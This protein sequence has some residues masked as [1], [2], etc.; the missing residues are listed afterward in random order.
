[1]SGTNS[2]Q[3]QW[4]TGHVRV[5]AAVFL[6]LSMLIS[7]GLVALAQD[8]LGARAAQYGVFCIKGTVIDHDETPLEGFVVRA[9]APTGA[10]FDVESDEDGYFEFL[11]LDA[12]IYTV[13]VVLERAYTL[14][15]PYLQVLSVNLEYGDNECVEIRFKLRQLVLVNVI[16][17]DDQHN[18]LDG[19]LITAAPAKDNWFAYA[20]TEETGAAD[21][22]YY[23]PSDPAGSISFEPGQ[24]LFNLT[25]GN[26]I[27]SEKPPAP[28]KEDD[29]VKFRPIVPNTGVQTLD[30]DCELVNAENQPD[31]EGTACRPINIRFKNL[32]K[33]A[34]IEAFKVDSFEGETTKTSTGLANWKIS[35]LR[36]DGTVVASGLTDAQGRIEFEHLKPGKYKVV[37]EMQPGWIVDPS[38]PA[39]QDVYIV[40]VVNS[41]TCSQVQFQ[42]IQRN[43]FCIDGEKFDTF[44]GIGLPGWKITATPIKKGDYP[45]PGVDP[46][47]R[48]PPVPLPSDYDP[49]DQDL[50]IFNGKMVTVTDNLGEFEFVFPPN[51]YRI[52]GAGY[53]ICEE[54]MDGWLAHTPLC[55]TVYLPKHPGACVEAKGFENQQVGHWESVVYGK[56]SGSSG[57]GCSSTYTVQ[58]GDSLYG[59]GAMYGA[60]ASAMMS[61]N[62]WVYGRPQYYL[63]VGD[64]ICIP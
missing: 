47:V 18:L 13:E 49:N 38:S 33:N 42:N 6:A 12:G 63:Y 8:D 11:N 44:G 34:C 54:T 62:P 30:I 37:E 15:P 51:D 64:S 16:K 20:M 2:S 56:H 55:Q 53:K 46:E 58:R 36:I 10:S 9:T 17:I 7:T 25:P 3:R 50:G 61:S 41:E 35:V 48:I 57:A 26:W 31:P 28:S 43:Q 45:T 32:I 59:I 19:W 52:P 1:M 21:P 23:E 4:T 27:F 29:P 39:Y 40:D 60:S 14:V 24:V 5:L 22:E